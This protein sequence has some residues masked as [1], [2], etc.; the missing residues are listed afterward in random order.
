MLVIAFSVTA[1]FAQGMFQK[2]NKFEF[3][4][5]KRNHS[6]MMAG[7]E[8]LD[9]LNLTEAQ[10]EN[11]D[12]L[13]TEHQKKLIDIRAKLGKLRIDKKEALRNSNF[14]QAEK[15]AG[16]ISTQRAIISK[17]RIQL[18]KQIFNLLDKEQQAKYGQFRKEHHP[19]M[20]NRQ[21]RHPMGMNRPSLNND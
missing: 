21:E 5:S 10:R 7:R 13:I 4:R 2:G 6:R 17:E 8:I 20:G 12:K 18:Q 11:I 3:G 9:R 19:L 1:I 16:K 15:I 14:N